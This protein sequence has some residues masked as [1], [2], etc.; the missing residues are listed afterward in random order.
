MKGAKIHKD[1]HNFNNILEKNDLSENDKFI[2]E[3][4][5]GKWNITKQVFYI[6]RQSIE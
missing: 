4:D 1:Q 6:S 2:I 3:I 5:E